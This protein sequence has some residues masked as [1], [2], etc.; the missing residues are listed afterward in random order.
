MFTKAVYDNTAECCIEILS[1]THPTHSFT[2]EGTQNCDKSLLLSLAKQTYKGIPYTDRQYDLAKE[3]INLYRQLLTDIGVEVDLAIDTLRKPLR[4]IDRSRWIG[5]REKDGIDYIAVRFT[6]NKKLISVI[7]SL[8]NKENIKMYDEQNKIHYFPL[9]ESNIFNIVSILQDRNFSIESNITEKYEKLQIMS[10]NRKDYIPGVYGF[11]LKNLNTKA[12]EYMISD[13]GD[14][15]SPENLALYKDRDALYG[16]EHFDDHDL[17]QS[18]NNLT[19]LS[20]RIVRRTQ[21]QVLINSSEFTINNVA[22]SILELNRY[23]LLVCLAPP[24]DLDD[25]TAVYQ[26]FRNIFSNDDNCVLYRKDNDTADNKYFNQFVKQNSLNNPLGKNAKIVY[27][28]QEKLNKPLL[29]T[30]WKP[31]SALVFG[32]S[33]NNKLSTYLGEMDLVM[34]YDTDISPFLAKTVEKI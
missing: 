34:Y 14:E 25:L 6:F 29:K 31:K 11:K 4:H 5:V 20:Q 27:T 13:I 28:T 16:I 9:T 8:R 18:V 1:G 26:C 3:K 24:T 12:V 17:D 15:P 7:D 21:T 2:G 32:S 22:E 30:T 33:R 10:N 19:T 23:P